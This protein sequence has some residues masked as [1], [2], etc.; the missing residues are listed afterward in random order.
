MQRM[1]VIYA[2]D[3]KIWELDLPRRYQLS[4]IKQVSIKIKNIVLSKQISFPLYN[5]ALA[6][7]LRM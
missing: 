6:T 1:S 2:F 4:N 5:V 3:K 7:T